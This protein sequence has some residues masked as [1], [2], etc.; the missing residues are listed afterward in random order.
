MIFTVRFT[1]RCRL[2]FSSVFPVSGLIGW[3]APRRGP[4]RWAPLPGR[5]RRQVHG[6]GS[7]QPRKFRLLHRPR[8]R[9]CPEKSMT[10]VVSV[11][12]RR[13]S[14]HPA[15]TAGQLLSDL[16]PLSLGS[17]RPGGSRTGARDWGSRVRRASAWAP[18][19][20]DPQPRRSSFRHGCNLRGTS[21][22]RQE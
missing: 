6:R 13:Q 20:G 10:V 3:A 16:P 1:R 11:P 21:W 9:A 7:L 15:S 12:S 17:S 4:D 19:S 18:R 14:Y 22:S 8:S 5:E 2:F